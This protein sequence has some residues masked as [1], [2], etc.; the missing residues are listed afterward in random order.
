GLVREPSGN[1]RAIS[2]V[3]P[4]SGFGPAEQAFNDAIARGGRVDMLVDGR[5]AVVDGV[6][7]VLGPDPD[8]NAP[9][10]AQPTPA[11]SPTP[12]EKPKNC[13]DRKPQGA[14]DL[15]N[16]GWVLY[17]PAAPN[18]RSRG[19]KA[20]L[21][22]YDS[23]HQTAPEVDPAGWAGT[24]SRAR[25][26]VAGAP[27]VSAYEQQNPLARCHFLA[28]R[29]G[30]S[31][32]EVLNFTPCWQTPVNVGITGMSAAEENVVYALTSKMIVEFR[33]FA[34]YNSST[35]DTPSAYSTLIYGQMPDS[36]STVR[37]SSPVIPNT[38]PV[39]GAPVNIGN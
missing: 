12:D 36:D 23:G 25:G 1:Y 5:P 39:N 15:P 17:L 6:D 9:A 16:K 28:A 4:G 3:S 29:F 30:G 11:P 14:Q 10:D 22:G 38:K 13:T 32:K 20:C 24:L 35:S 7:T 33:E 19:M 2:V 8:V 37:F 18:G 34:L 27:D 31:N 21:V 26:I